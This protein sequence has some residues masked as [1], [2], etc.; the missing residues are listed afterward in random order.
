V[1]ELADLFRQADAAWM[2]SRPRAQ[3]AVVDQIL[4]CRTAVLGGKLFRCDRCEAER[5]SYHSCRNRHCPKCHR[6]QTADWLEAWQTRLLPCGYFLVTFTLPAQLRPLARAHPKLIYD[7]LFTAA[8]GALQRLAADPK[9]LGAKLGLLGVLHTWT[10]TLTFHPHVHFLVTAGG[11]SVD[12]ERWID[13]RHR[14]F[15]V[16]CRV[17]SAVFRGLVK[18]GL[19]RAGLLAKIEARFWRKPWVVHAQ[20]AGRG[21]KALDYLARYVLRIAITNNRLE[22]FE[23]DQVT[24]RYRDN[25]TQQLQRCVLPLSE[26]LRRFLLH[27]LP[28]RFTKVRAYGLFGSRATGLRD[29]VRGLISSGEPAMP[30]TSP[31]LDRED[32]PA[33][34]T[35]GP[36]PADCEDRCP[37]CKQGTLR[38]VLIIARWRG[39]PA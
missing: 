10:R 14:R 33:T 12:G 25:R 5:Y 13:P 4:H 2:T 23:H 15:L 1:L 30:T 31:P 29:K 8:A 28:A 37:S 17:L 19:K 32:Q 22:R 16:P 36:A 38:V 20:H 21:G 18:H 11:L 26:F 9:Y 24:F 7:L 6:E 3:R 35:P 39:P 34:N 27:V